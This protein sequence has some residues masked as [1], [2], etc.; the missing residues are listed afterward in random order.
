MALR[1]VMPWRCQAPGAATILHALEGCT[2]KKVFS[3]FEQ[4]YNAGVWFSVHGTTLENRDDLRAML[5]A[6]E[7]DD[8]ALVIRGALKPEL[9]HLHG[10]C[11]RCCH[12]QTDGHPAAFDAAARY[13][14]AL[15]FDSVP[16][17]SGV[18]P[19]DPIMAGG[20]CRLLLPKWAQWAGYVSQLTS[21]AGRKPGLRCRLWAWCDRPVS[22]AEWKRLLRDVPVDTAL[23]N[24]VQPHYTA[25]PFFGEL[26]EDRCTEGRLAVLP[27]LP[28]MVVPPAPEPAR[29]A[30]TGRTY[31]FSQPGGAA[32]STIGFSQPIRRSI[33]KAT[34]AERYALAC[35]RAIAAARP[36]ESHPTAVRASCKLLGMARAGLLDPRDVAA[37]IKGALMSKTHRD[38]TESEADGI[39]TWAW[40][41][42]SEHSGQ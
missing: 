21:G 38:I 31:S 28:E 25:A 8:T 33:F 26:V 27:G 13:W 6:L 9:L 3:T 34:R 42:V 30:A 15:D 24:A 32:G 14:A 4:E 17:P 40:D 39:L 19:T 12:D 22:D 37:R 18:D 11:R 29:R 2:A 41:R 1:E 10:R 23:F 35:Y 16:C 7:P 5:A 36:G 20:A